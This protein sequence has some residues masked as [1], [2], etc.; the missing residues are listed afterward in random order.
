MAD[1]TH[2]KSITTGRK[3]NDPVESWMASGRGLSRC[4]PSA[5]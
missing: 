2:Q 1:V 4:W 3:K 5:R